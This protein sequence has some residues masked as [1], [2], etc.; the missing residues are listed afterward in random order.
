M[1]KSKNKKKKQ[2]PDK[3]LYLEY[4]ELT[5]NQQEKHRQNEKLITATVELKWKKVQGDMGPPR[6]HRGKEVICHCRRCKRHGFNP[7]VRKIPWRRAWQPISIF[8]PGEFR[9]TEEPGGLQ[10]IGSQSDL[11]HIHREIWKIMG[12]KFETVALL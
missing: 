3:E 11:A 9:W 12:L 2:L 4:S 5:K 6:R 8:L 1:K 10:S 7:W